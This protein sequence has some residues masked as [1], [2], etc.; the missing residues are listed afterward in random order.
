MFA[1]VARAAVDSFSGRGE[2]AVPGR[3]ERAGRTSTGSTIRGVG[4]M[5]RPDQK[6]CL[7]FFQVSLSR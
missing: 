4:P 2:D 3:R 7:F 1:T 6:A 5:R